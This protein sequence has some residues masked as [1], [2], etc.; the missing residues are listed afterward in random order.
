MITV[1][2]LTDLA[3]VNALAAQ[4]DALR[5]GAAWPSL[6]VGAQW[7]LLWMRHWMAGKKPYV[8]AAYRGEELVA[9]MPLVVGRSSWRR[10]PVRA[11]SFCAN[12]HSLRGGI[13]VAD[14]DAE[15]VA[16]A[17]TKFLSRQ[18]DWDVFVID[19]IDDG[20]PAHR[21]L[22]GAAQEAGLSLDARGEWEHCHLAVE[23]TMESY[24][25]A[26]ASLKRSLK[27]SLTAMEGL[28]KVEVVA[29]RT[30]EEIRAAVPAF[31][32]ID[33]AS[34][35]R[36]GGE[37]ITSNPATH[38]FYQDMFETFATAGKARLLMMRVDGH[39]ACGVMCVL[40]EGVLYGMKTSFREALPDGRELATSKT[41]PGLHILHEMVREAYAS[42]ARGLD[43]VSKYPMVERFCETSRRFTAAAVHGASLYPRL[44]A[45][46]DRGI[47]R[48]RID[49]KLRAM[50]VAR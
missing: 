4:W 17:F 22:A 2:K 49:V 44:L 12:N 25:A 31:L 41:S 10:L 27:R 13:A 21:V 16:G 8:L 7:N 42:G 3:E 29:H 43:F 18:R 11:L 26:R 30:A 20:A 32:E 23:G 35:K 46:V 38:A 36:D 14:A 9:V 37:T 28:G 24:M 5:A 6:F 45:G 15:S 40:D 33:A 47:R 39:W 1:R 19:G 34:W 48:F 50:G